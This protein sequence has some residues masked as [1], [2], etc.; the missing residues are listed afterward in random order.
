MDRPLRGVYAPLSSNERWDD[1]NHNKD[2]DPKF[3]VT[4]FFFN[5][6]D[7]RGYKIHNACHN[8]A[9]RLLNLDSTSVLERWFQI[10][11]ALPKTSIRNEYEWDHF[12]GLPLKADWKSYFPWEHQAYAIVQ[13]NKY[14]PM[15]SANPGVSAELHFRSRN[16]RDVFQ[17]PFP[18][19]TSQCSVESGAFARLPWELLELIA[20]LLPTKTALQLRLVSRF[21]HP[22]IDSNPFW[23]SRFQPDNERGELFEFTGTKRN[24]WLQLYRDTRSAEYSPGLENRKRIW[25]LLIFLRDLI[26]IPLSSEDALVTPV[27]SQ[28]KW[29]T[30]ELDD[31]RSWAWP[32]TQVCTKIG[33]QET[34]VPDQLVEIQVSVL[35]FGDHTYITGLRLITDFLQRIS[36]GYFDEAKSVSF[37]LTAI[38][39]FILAMGPHGVRAIKVVN[40][41]LQASRWA[42]DAKNVPH[43]RRLF[44]TQSLRALRVEFDVSVVVSPPLSIPL[45][46]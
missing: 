34:A 8:M 6:S 3:E 27:P 11:N 44:A 10:L 43:S 30:I 7:R 35:Q 28:H 42:G 16:P 2:L 38:R 22:L 36:L 46:M 4:R 1:A 23:A 14:E 13:Y 39:G 15:L 32:D 24:N 45:T 9:R 31:Q 25:K 40:D 41:N 18:P 37:K 26:R 5:K 33:S 17:D 21:F 19:H 12:Y 29:T 20:Q